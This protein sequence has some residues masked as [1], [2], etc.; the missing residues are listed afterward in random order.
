MQFHRALFSRHYPYYEFTTEAFF[1]KRNT[2]QNDIIRF[3]NIPACDIATP[4]L[5]QISSS[6][7]KDEI[8]NC[9][10]VIDSLKSTEYA[11]LLND[12][13]IQQHGDE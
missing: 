12:F 7:I 5:Q 10:D 1:S 6:H 3:L 4:G 8:Y 13:I 11:Y 2:I 9:Q